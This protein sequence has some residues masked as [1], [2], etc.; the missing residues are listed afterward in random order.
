MIS[1]LPLTIFSPPNLPHN[2]VSCF[3]LALSCWP[4]NFC[5]CTQMIL[6]CTVQI[7]FFI[8][9]FVIERNIKCYKIDNFF[10]Q[11]ILFHLDSVRCYQKYFE[12]VFFT[13]FIILIYIHTH[14]QSIGKT[15]PSFFPRKFYW[16]F[17]K[18]VNLFYRGVP[19][20][21]ELKCLTADSKLASLNS[22]HAIM[23]PFGQIPLGKK[24]KLPYLLSYELN[25]IIAVLLWLW[26]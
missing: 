4:C 6:T 22:I 12:L 17:I 2:Y 16:S 11:E 23:F 3:W 13:A 14:T 25:S 21:S 15:E 8:S 20:A 24:Y 1:P 26:H 10:S 19:I 5:F 7:S 18:L 9:D